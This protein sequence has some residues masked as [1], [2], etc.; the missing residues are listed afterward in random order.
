MGDHDRG[1]FQ[2]EHLVALKD[3]FDEI[4]AQPWFDASEKSKDEFAKYLI[5]TFPG[6]QFN[7]RKHRMVIETSAR[8]FYSRDDSRAH[9]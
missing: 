4:T 5:S 6:D 7:P 8:M 9:A 3:A 2:P 1:I